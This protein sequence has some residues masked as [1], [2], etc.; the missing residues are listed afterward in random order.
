MPSVFRQHCGSRTS[1]KIAIVR[2]FVLHR[3]GRLI[4]CRRPSTKTIFTFNSPSRRLL[5]NF[6]MIFRCQDHSTQK[7]KH[8][9]RKTIFLSSYTFFMSLRLSSFRNENTSRNNRITQCFR[10]TFFIVFLVGHSS[11]QVSRAREPNKINIW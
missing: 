10:P 4:T 8:H 1:L 2:H 7:V 9:R 5:F 11:R 3:L 6:M